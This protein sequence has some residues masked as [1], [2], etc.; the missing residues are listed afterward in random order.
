M[1]HP[2]PGNAVAVGDK[3]AVPRSDDGGVGAVDAHAAKVLF[4]HAA[5]TAGVHQQEG[6]AVLPKIPPSPAAPAVIVVG[7][8][9]TAK[10]PPQK[11]LETDP[12]HQVVKVGVAGVEGYVD[13]PLPGGAGFGQGRPGLFLAAVALPGPVQFLRRP[14]DAQQQHIGGLSPRCQRQ[15]RQPERPHRLTAGRCA[16]GRHAGAAFHHGAGAQVSPSLA[17]KGFHRGIKPV[18]LLAAGPCAQHI[19]QRA[20][21][22]VAPL[23]KGHGG[24]HGHAV[25]GTVDAV[26]HRGHIAVVA[27]VVRAAAIEGHSGKRGGLQRPGAGVAHRHQHDLQVVRKRAEQRDAGGDPQ[28]AGGALHRLP[29][30]AGLQ[31]AVLLIWGEFLGLLPGGSAGAG[32]GLA[33]AAQ[34]EVAAGAV[35]V[36]IFCADRLQ[37]KRLL[38]QLGIAAQAGS[39][40]AFHAGIRRQREIQIADILRPVYGEA[41]AFLQK[42]HVRQRSHS[43]PFICFSH[44]TGPTGTQK[45]K[46]CAKMAE[47]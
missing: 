21:G 3:I 5:H 35:V 6:Q 26:Q 27:D 40:G 28:R 4:D 2:D 41:A 31:A 36:Q 32:P 44:Y 11:R 34:P 1:V 38:V 47:S 17:Q 45:S 13:P 7:Q 29:H 8:E 25:G 16:A 15:V 9:G 24:L 10:Q 46:R 39:Y 18:R 20:V 19:V 33:A 22:A 23:V 42:R 12:P 14:G 43:F 30:Q 37:Q